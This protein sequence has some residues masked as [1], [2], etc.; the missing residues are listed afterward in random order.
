MNREWLLTGQL[1]PGD[2]GQV[3]WEEGVAKTRRLWR[4]LWR[5]KLGPE[6]RARRLGTGRQESSS[7]GRVEWRSWKGV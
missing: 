5:E 4:G 3:P 2:T 1:C 6:A 7:E